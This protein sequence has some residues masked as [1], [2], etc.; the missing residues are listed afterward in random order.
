MNKEVNFETAKILKEKGFSWECRHFYSK[1]KY[2][3]EFYLRTGLEYDSDRDCIWDWNLNGGKSG[4][5]LKTIPYPNDGTA[6]Y[7]SA[8]IIEDVCMW[9]Y[10]KHEIWIYL[11]PAEDN[12]KVFK[13]FFRGENITDQHLTK[14]FES[15]TEAYEA[16]IT[17]TLEKLIQGGKK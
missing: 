10:E 9:L 14:F 15:P 3:Q 16:A 12:K 2:D 8:P 5:L 17:Y 13:P 7:Y 6:I 1:N 11:I 4:M